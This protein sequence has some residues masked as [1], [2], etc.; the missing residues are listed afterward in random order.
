LVMSATLDTA[1]I[2][3]YLDDCPALEC[4]GRLF[5]VDIQYSHSTAGRSISDR[6]ARG[7]QQLLDHSAG[8]LL[9]FLTGVRE[10]RQTSRQLAET[11]RRADLSLL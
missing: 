9:V 3:R 10:I 2:S 5:P 7:V 8:D 4:Q 11:T 6:A 1:P